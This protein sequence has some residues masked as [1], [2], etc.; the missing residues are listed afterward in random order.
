ME[1]LRRHSQ[2]QTITVAGETRTIRPNQGMVSQLARRLSDD[3][4]AYV[5]LSGLL[6]LAAVTWRRYGLSAADLADLDPET[7][8]HVRLVAG[9]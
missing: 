5:E 9:M 7:L 1:A 3:H 8:A 2:P 4:P 6:R